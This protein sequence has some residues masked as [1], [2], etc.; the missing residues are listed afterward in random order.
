MDCLELSAQLNK[1]AGLLMKLESFGG[2]SRILRDCSIGHFAKSTSRAD[3]ILSG[4]VN[5]LGR[6]TG[7]GHPR[8]T[9]SGRYCG[10]LLG[11]GAGWLISPRDIP[12]P[13]SRVIN[14]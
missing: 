10:Y 8:V 6:S 9:C 1:R 11:A 2:T 5:L 13:G 3:A 7:P 12:V 14:T 4:E